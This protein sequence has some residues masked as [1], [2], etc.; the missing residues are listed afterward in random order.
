MAVKD[1]RSKEQVDI[2]FVEFILDCLGNLIF[3]LAWPNQKPR[4]LKRMT[5]L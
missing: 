1:G 4:F 3:I 2:A 5:D